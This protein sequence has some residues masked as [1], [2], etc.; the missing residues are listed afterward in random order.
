MLYFLLHYTKKIIL[1]LS[2]KL[3]QEFC[4]EKLPQLTTG[5]VNFCISKLC[6]VLHG[7]RWISSGAVTPSIF[8]KF[9]SF[10]VKQER[11][12]DVQSL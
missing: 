9:Q 8:I 4:E 11:H 10:L 7:M 5:E 6:F 3:V 2:K 12:S 1:K